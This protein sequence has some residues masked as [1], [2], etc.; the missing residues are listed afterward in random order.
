MTERKRSIEN[1]WIDPDDAPEWSDEAFARAEIRI[2]DRVVRPASGTLNKGGRPRLEKP[3]KQVTLRLDQS[4]IEKLRDSGPG[5][6][7]RA[8][9]ILRKALQV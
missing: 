5:W 7:G 6:Q 4:V 2:G 8:N 9:D 1:T 3:K